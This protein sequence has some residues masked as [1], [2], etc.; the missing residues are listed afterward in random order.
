MVD[1]VSARSCVVVVGS[2]TVVIVL[3]YQGQCM[4]QDI[5]IIAISYHFGRWVG[6]TVRSFET[7]E[8]CFYEIELNGCRSALLFV[9]RQENKRNQKKKKNK[10]RISCEALCHVGRA[11]IS[12][13]LRSKT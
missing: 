4:N 13:E 10:K 8:C 12:N 11:I 9:P 7:L 2:V 1:D 3:R 6:R 5:N